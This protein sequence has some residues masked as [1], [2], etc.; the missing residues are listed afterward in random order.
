V[1]FKKLA[2]NERY[3][4]SS[5]ERGGGGIFSVSMIRGLA[6]ERGNSATG[7]TA[8]MLRLSSFLLDSICR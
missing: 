5:T 6:A 7:D 3:V 4:F 8:G 1:G 2:V